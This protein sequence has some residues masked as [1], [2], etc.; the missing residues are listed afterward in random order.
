MIKTPNILNIRD[1]DKKFDIVEGKLGVQVQSYLNHLEPTIQLA[2]RKIF[3]RVIFVRGLNVSNELPLA[4]Y[5]NKATNNIVINIDAFKSPIYDIPH[6]DIIAAIL[7]ASCTY[8]EP[9][10]LVGAA[11]DFLQAYIVRVFGKQ[12]GVLNTPQQIHAIY[13][14]CRKYVYSESLTILDWVRDLGKLLHG[15]NINVFLNGSLRLVTLSSLPLFEVYSRLLGAMLAGK[16][17]NGLVGFLYKFNS[18]ACKILI[19][20]ALATVNN[21]PSNASK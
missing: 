3:D 11:A 16:I 18:S 10:R 4:S 1:I 13:G 14:I 19:N 15:F 5:Y 6:R 7:L 20:Q 21:F 12:F 8:T 17:P 2:L 9:K